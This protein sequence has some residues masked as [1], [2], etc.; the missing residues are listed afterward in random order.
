VRLILK[1]EDSSHPQLSG[2]KWRKLKYNLLAAEAGG[3]DT[4]LSFGG[5]YSN[6]I[7]ALAA[8]GRLFGLRT[9]GVIRGEAHAPLNP[10]LRFADSCGMSLHYLDRQT[11][12]EKHTP[13]VLEDLRRRFGRFYLI[14]EGGSN[15][16]AVR[17]CREIVAEIG[18]DFTH[19]CCA[20][21][22][23]GTLAGLIAGLDGRKTVLGFPV[24]KGADFLH[25]EIERLLAEAGLANPGNWALM[26]D[27]HFGGYAKTR[28]ELL[29]FI[30]DF[31]RRTGVALDPVYTGKL[32][33]GIYDLL[34]RGFFQPGQTVLAIHTGGLQ[35]ASPVSC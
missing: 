14:P 6:H 29:D 5:A 25:G 21:G 28:P 32:L 4:L 12:R 17:G 1:R 11:Y 19:L 18:E 9:I 34:K 24:L 30:A 35:A 27:Y 26:L 23:G 33:A 3:H 8:A 7:F 22:T 2:N 10:T 16:L 31:H 15:A 13:A 20:C